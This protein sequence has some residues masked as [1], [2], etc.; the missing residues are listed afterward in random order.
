MNNLNWDD[1]RYFLALVDKGSVTGAARRLDVEHT[2]VSRRISALE[3]ALGFRL[4]DRLPRAWNLTPE[5]ENLVPQARRLE[6]EA[7]SLQRAAVGV[8]PLSGT[9]RISAPPVMASH[10]LVPRLAPLRRGLPGVT[11]ELVG[12]TREANLTRREADIALRLS[13]PSAEGLVARSLVDIGYGLYGARTYVAQV[14][15]ENWEFV[16][17]EESL[18]GTPQQQWL[19]KTAGSRAFSF[20]SND[21]GSLHQAVKAGLGVGAL[22]HFL[23][24]DDPSLMLLAPDCPVTRTLWLVMHPDVRRSPRVRAVADAIVG[25]LTED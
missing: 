1:L 24:A 13:R 25:I 2:T 17:Y 20:R 14:S 5:G 3:A 21:L 23:A 8:A 7:L 10:L 6:E 11:L 22:P 19:E 9:V 4:F 15:S 18:L 16:G 12:E